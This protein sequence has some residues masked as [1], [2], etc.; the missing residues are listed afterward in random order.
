MGALTRIMPD[1]DS[2][3]KLLPCFNCGSE[4]VAYEFAARGRRTPKRVRCQSCGLSLTNDS[5]GTMHD[6]QIL[7]NRRYRDGQRCSNTRPQ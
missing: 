4:Q 2:Q 3:Y 6:L 7:W 1:R 5:N